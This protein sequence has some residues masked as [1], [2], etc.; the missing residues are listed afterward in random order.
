MPLEFPCLYNK[1]F[2]CGYACLFG[3][4]RSL[5]PHASPL[6]NLQ[7][8][9]PK[10]QRVWVSTSI[11]HA[12]IIARGVPCDKGEPAIHHRDLPLIYIS[13]YIT[14]IFEEKSSEQ[15]LFIETASS[16]AKLWH[17]M[18]SCTSIAH[19]LLVQVLIFF[20]L[21]KISKKLISLLWKKQWNY[22]DSGVQSRKNQTS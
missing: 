22:P 2:R 4:Y 11:F 20:F 6:H 8:H 15:N 7:L 5:I 13:I 3:L 10:L 14:V 18:Y 17:F 19:V 12:L 1:P 9:R 16:P 21:W